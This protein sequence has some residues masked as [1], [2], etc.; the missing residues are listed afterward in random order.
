MKIPLSFQMNVC[1]SIVYYNPTL[2]CVVL[3]LKSMPNPGKDLQFCKDIV[4]M[5]HEHKFKDIILLDDFYDPRINLRQSNLELFII[6][7][8]HSVSLQSCYR[9]NNTWICTRSENGALTRCELVTRWISS[10]LI[11][12][13]FL[14][15]LYLNSTSLYRHILYT[16]M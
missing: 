1:D 8:C 12:H 9:K 3:A 14:L 4:K 7:E 10:T 16:Q 2:G 6:Q 11:M 5:Y 13:L 15:I